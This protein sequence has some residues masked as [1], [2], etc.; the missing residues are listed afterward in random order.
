MPKP[1]TPPAPFVQAP[2][3]EPII[4]PK[5]HATPPPDE[6]TTVEP[7]PPVVRPKSSYKNTTQPIYK[8]A[9]DSSTIA[10]RLIPR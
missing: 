9:H 1:T 2:K 8:Y 4:A 3:L 5:R 7:I 6:E 10:Y